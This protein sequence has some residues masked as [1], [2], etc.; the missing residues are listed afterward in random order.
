MRLMCPPPRSCLRR[1]RRPKRR[2]T[3]LEASLSPRNANYSIDARLDAAR[4][5]ITG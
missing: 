1:S 4:P 5:T 2:R 3:A